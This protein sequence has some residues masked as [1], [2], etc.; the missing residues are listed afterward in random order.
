MRTSQNWEIG[1]KVEWEG[2]R[3]TV[4]SKECRLEKGLLQFYYTL[5]GRAA[6]QIERYENP[7][8]T[9]LMLP[10]AVL[11]VKEEQVKVK[12]DMDPAQPAVTGF[13]DKF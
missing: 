1:D 10:A 5:A 8:L 12:F 7:Y 4:S 3:Y 2:S 13:S 11:D 6:F 9:G